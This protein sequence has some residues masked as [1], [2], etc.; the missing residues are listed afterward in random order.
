MNVND[1]AKDIK[2]QFIADLNGLKLT[3]EEALI[4]N[5][6]SIRLALYGTNLGGEAQYA[7]DLKSAADLAIATLADI[8]VAKQLKAEQ[9]VRNAAFTVLTRVIG[10]ALG[11]VA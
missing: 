11:A 3:E 7:A 9:I 4:V 8:G 5:D 6:A 10:I 2:E 1:I